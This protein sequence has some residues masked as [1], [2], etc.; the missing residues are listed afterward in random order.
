VHENIEAAKILDDLLDAV[1]ARRG[2]G[3]VGFEGTHHRPVTFGGS[4]ELLRYL[5]GPS[6]K[7]LDVGSSVR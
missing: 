7:D 5:S 3:Y 4:K 6:C 1:S 2:V